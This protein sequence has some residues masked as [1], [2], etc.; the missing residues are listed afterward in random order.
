MIRL[1]HKQNEQKSLTVY[2]CCPNSLFCE[3][4]DRDALSQFNDDMYAKWRFHA[5]TQG[6]RT[7]KTFSATGISLYTIKNTTSSAERWDHSDKIKTIR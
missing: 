2:F 6:I 5:L 7:I 4:F 3:D 1:I